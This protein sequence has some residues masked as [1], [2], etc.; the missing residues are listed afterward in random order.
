MIG[1]AFAPAHITGFFYIHE[2]DNPLKMGSCGCGIALEDGVISKVQIAEDTSIRLNGEPS[3]APTTRMAIDLLTDM[4][5]K[6]ESKLAFPVGGGFGDSGA[7]AFSAVIALNRAL[8][9]NRTFNELAYTAHMAE[10]KNGTGL[11]DV[12]GAGY[13]DYRIWVCILEG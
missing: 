8:G 2:D 3:D 1:K 12:A 5:V 9:L 13:P 4:P 6:V 10:V 7:G 11:G